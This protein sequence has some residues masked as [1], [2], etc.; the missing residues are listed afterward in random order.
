MC[1]PFPLTNLFGSH[2]RLTRLV[3]K[4]IFQRKTEAPRLRNLFLRLP[5]G[6]AGFPVD[7]LALAESRHSQPHPSAPEMPEL[8]L[9]L[10]KIVERSSERSLSDRRT[11]RYLQLEPSF[12]A[13]LIAAAS[14]QEASLETAERWQRPRLPSLPLS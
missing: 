6:V 7:G 1:L 10:L 14:G 12:P 9:G 13:A 2:W 4:L 3:I 8:S 5:I 11:E